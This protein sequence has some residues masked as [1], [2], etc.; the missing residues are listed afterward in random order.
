MKR[1]IYHYYATIENSQCTVDGI[2][3]MKKQILSM[4]DYHELKMEINAK[5]RI[6]GVSKV[7]IAS[8]S[9]IGESND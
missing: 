3:K 1:F 4:E 2:A 7:T 5:F 6:G 9:L 8:L